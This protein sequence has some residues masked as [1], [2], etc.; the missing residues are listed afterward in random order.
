MPVTLKNIGK[1]LKGFELKDLSFNIGE[2]EYFVLLGPSGSGKTK[3]IEMI[4]GLVKPDSGL[5]SGVAGKNMGFIYQDYM[6]FPHM[7]VFENI[8]FGLKV[9]KFPADE[10]KKVVNG[11]AEMFDISHLL[12]KNVKNLSGGEKQR[13][14]IAR[15]TVISPDIYILDE[16]TSALDRNLKVKTESLFRNLHHDTKK[17]FIHVT[18]DFE[19]ALALGDRIAI[20]FNGEIV[21]TGSPDEIFSTPASKEIADFIGY[22]NVIKGRIDNNIFSLN[23]VS[24]TVPEEEA[25]LAYIAIRP[26][27]IFLSKKKISSSARNSFCGVVT[28]II[29]KPSSIEIILDIGFRLTVNITR[30]SLL[31]MGIK[32]GDKLWATFKVSSIK[33]FKH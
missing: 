20:I 15:A 25:S 30:K 27:D 6:L 3:T 7:S 21:Q 1:K 33:V 10:I 29:H 9:R 23:G 4:A 16:P 32:K 24:I 11:A 5:I 22:R 2:G 19:I 17:I 13:V 8:S 18:H 14:A 12:D 26:D 31:E 28:G